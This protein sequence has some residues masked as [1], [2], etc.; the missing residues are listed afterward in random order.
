MVDFTPDDT[1]EL[2]AWRAEVRAFLEAACR[3]A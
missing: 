3:A 2:K 1:P